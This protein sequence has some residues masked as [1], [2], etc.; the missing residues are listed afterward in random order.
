MD[1]LTFSTQILF[2]S[3]LEIATVHVDFI[4]LRQLFPVHLLENQSNSDVYRT[5]E[6][7][8]FLV[9]ELPLVEEIAGDR[10]GIVDLP[11]IFA[12]ITNGGQRIIAE[13]NRIIFTKKLRMKKDSVFEVDLTKS[14][15]IF[16]FSK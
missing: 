12:Y 8:N 14:S 4:D 13:D 11:C 7:W 1:D 6:E 10:M 3:N 9:V 2:H 15:R 5:E 16:V